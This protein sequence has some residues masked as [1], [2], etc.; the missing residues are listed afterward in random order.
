MLTFILP[1]KGMLISG[2]FPCSEQNAVN[3]FPAPSAGRK[4]LGTGVSEQIFSI[5]G[6]LIDSSTVCDFFLFVSFEHQRF[7]E[8]HWLPMFPL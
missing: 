1:G 8:L 3:G 7:S 2:A 6:Y 4:Q 5:L